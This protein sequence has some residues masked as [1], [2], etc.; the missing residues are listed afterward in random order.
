[1]RDKIRFWLERNT[2]SDIKFSILAILLGI[3]F[4]VVLVIGIIIFMYTLAWLFSIPNLIIIVFGTIG[5]I[6]WVWIA[7]ASLLLYM[8]GG[9]E[10]S[11]GD[12]LKCLLPG[13]DLP[14][15]NHVIHEPPRYPTD[16]ADE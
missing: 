3:P 13:C 6:F 12:P 7:G 10:N 14:R 15:D 5:I 8:A 4:T 2:K 16:E 1:M 11:E 9:P